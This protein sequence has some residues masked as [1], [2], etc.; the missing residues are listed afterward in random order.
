[1]HAGNFTDAAI[2]AVTTTGTPGNTATVLTLPLPLTDR[3][4]LAPASATYV[5]E[6]SIAEP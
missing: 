1:M 2:S 4:A 6:P 3:T 5:V